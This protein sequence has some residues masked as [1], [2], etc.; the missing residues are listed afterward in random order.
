MNPNWLIV[1]EGVSCPSGADA[2]VWDNIPDEP[3]GWWGGN[4]SRAGQF[5]VR[6]STPA[7]LVYSAHDYAT[8]V[9]QQSWFSDPSFPAN[10]PAIWDRFWGY[11]E[12]Q[13]VAPVLV[14]E[15]GSTLADPRDAVWL[16]ELMRCGLGR[17]ANT[18]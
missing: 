16:R 9:Y 8:S 6:L 12:R 2:N 14:G 4:L 1:V 11:L 7:K 15:F 3:C 17:T 5:P 13:N 10:L 18:H